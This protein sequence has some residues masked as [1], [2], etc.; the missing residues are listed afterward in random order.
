MITYRAIAVN[1]PEV[2]QTVESVDL[3]NFIY[4]KPNLGAFVEQY[5]SWLD[6]PL[7]DWQA[8]VTD[9][10]TGA[11][12]NFE[13]E[14]PHLQ[15]VTFKGEYPYHRSLGAECVNLDQLQ[16]GMKLVISD[17]WAAT[18][19]RH[20]QLTD[21]Y[22][23]CNQKQ[24]PVF[25][26]RAFYGAAT[27]ELYIDECVTHIAY[28]FSKAFYTGRVKTGICFTKQHTVSPMRVLNEY[29]YVNSVGLGLHKVLM[30]KFHKFYIHNTY[31]DAQ[32]D[33]CKKLG[34][35]ASDTV[36]LGYTFDGKYKG[37]NREGTANRICFSN[38]FNTDTDITAVPWETK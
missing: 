32:L 36:F 1:D 29:A 33:Y 24:I 16:K 28:S 14:Y 27:T 37:F 31:R 6:E 34:I 4:S 23:V 21:I 7:N 22:L 8:F 12:D 2:K 13:R 3:H 35:T 10:V 17:P 11:Y 19:S 9:G 20:E 38:I 26:D 18:G 30:E 5:R 15:T 25:L